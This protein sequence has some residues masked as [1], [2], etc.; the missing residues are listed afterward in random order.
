L[1][2]SKV[3]NPV[4][5]ILNPPTLADRLALRER[6]SG[7]PLMHQQWGD[8][9]FMHWPV[10][11]EVIQPY[12][13]P[14]LRVDTHDG[15]AW[16]AIVPFRMWD[17]RSRVTPPV[18]GVREFLELNV[19]TYVHLDG[20]PGVWFF[21]L[22]ATNALAVWAARTFFHLPYFRARLSLERP[23]PDQ[24]RYVGHRVH[25]GAPDAHFTATWQLGAALPPV[26]PGS[27]TFFLTERYCLYAAA[28]GAAP[29]Q[30]ERLYRGRI[31]HAPWPLREIELL[32]F[33]SDLIEQH[34]L[35]V[36]V[37][38]PVLHAGGPLSVD[39]WQLRRV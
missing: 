36:P 32:N 28:G 22:D 35:P 10:P 12:L 21:S 34:G 7:S 37:G 19:R 4:S 27:L 23:A 17:V 8:L 31:A 38:A 9:L 24:L 30:G 33:Q 20:V 2:Q 29:G 3:L 16:L 11:A 15:Q 5:P 13:P 1:F 14:R 39:L 18:P 25:N 6:P 26:E